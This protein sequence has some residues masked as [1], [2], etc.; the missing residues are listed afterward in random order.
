MSTAKKA[1]PQAKAV[2]FSPSHD[3]G[4][5]IIANPDESGI[6]MKRSSIDARMICAMPDLL[7]LVKNILPLAIKNDA[8]GQW[9][10]DAR[11]AIAKTE[12]RA[13]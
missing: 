5:E 3:G 6:A 10:R 11:A 2:G 12:G 9:V 13:S 4:L 7:A 1:E 8:E